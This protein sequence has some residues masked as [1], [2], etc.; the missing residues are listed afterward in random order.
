[1]INEREETICQNQA[2]EQEHHNQLHRNFNNYKEILRIA[3]CKQ[4]FYLVQ[5]VAESQKVAM[6][7]V[8]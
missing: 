5:P 3:Q 6:V 4:M 7:G 2:G 1:L 8:P